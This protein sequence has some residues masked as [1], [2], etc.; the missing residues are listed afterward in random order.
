MMGVAVS[1]A[2]AGAVIGLLTIGTFFVVDNVWLDIVSRQQTKIDG[3]AHSGGGSMRDYINAGLAGAAI[4]L[5]IMLA[6][7]GAI[8]AIGGGGLAQWRT[9]S[10][11][12]VLD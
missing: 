12:R 5:P 11:G 8:L 4:L 10:A 2:V 9:Q 7:F 6:S 3:L 1:G